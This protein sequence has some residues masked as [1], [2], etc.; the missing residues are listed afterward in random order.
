MSGGSFNPAPNERDE[1]LALVRQM[2]ADWYD[3]IPTEQYACFEDPEFTLTDRGHRMLACRRSHTSRARKGGRTPYA[4]KD[5]KM[6]KRPR[7]GALLGW[8]ESATNKVWKELVEHGLVREDEKGRLWLCGRVSWQKKEDD[9]YLPADDPYIDSL[10]EKFCT[11]YF[12]SYLATQFQQLSKNERPRLHP[13]IEAWEAYEKQ[14]VAG[15]VAAAREAV[16]QRRDEYL[17]KTYRVKVRR[18]ER[19]PEEGAPKP[20]VQLSLLW[21][22]ELSVQNSEP[23]S[24]QGAKAGLYKV[25]NG[26]VQTTLNKEIRLIKQSNLPESESAATEEQRAGGE[27]SSEN[28]EE[29]GAGW[30]R[31]S[32]LTLAAGMEMTD[33][34]EGSSRVRYLGF[35][36]EERLAACRGIEERI[37]CGQYD[38]ANPS[39]KQYTP[40]VKNYLFDKRWKHDL[41]A[42][43][44]RTAPDTSVLDLLDQGFSEED[45]LRIVHESNGKRKKGPLVRHAGEGGDYAG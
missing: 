24:V 4:T 19:K 45:A 31:F 1:N 10:W 20:V 40:T 9:E 27:P 38:R 7:L 37:A 3:P 16:Q 22:P 18:F 12:P 11:D 26:N 36:I 14:V 17:A 21:E 15:A 13:D 41:R 39:R 34:E 23:K 8:D 32:E 29:E 43:A 25:E 33:A 6:L 5:G 42:P 30:A 2:G 44:G 28:G 35:P